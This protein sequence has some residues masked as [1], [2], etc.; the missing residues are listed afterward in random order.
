MFVKKKGLKGDFWSLGTWLKYK[1]RNML[2]HARKYMTKR[3]IFY[4]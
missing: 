1:D 3:F 2:S 4:N